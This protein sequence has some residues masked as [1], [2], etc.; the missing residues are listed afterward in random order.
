MIVD[1]TITLDNFATKIVTY[2]SAEP[3][4]GGSSGDYYDD[5]TNSLFYS[6]TTDDKEWDKSVL[7]QGDLVIQKDH[8]FTNSDQNGMIVI[9]DLTFNNEMAQGGWAW[10]EVMRSGLLGNPILPFLYYSHKVY[11]PIN[12]SLPMAPTGL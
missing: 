12:L 6:P 8:T 11:L 3:S 1:E 4:G 5:V 9:G 7:Y 10:G 2:S